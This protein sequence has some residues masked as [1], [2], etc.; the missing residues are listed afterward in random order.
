MS[1]IIPVFTNDQTNEEEVPGSS[2]HIVLNWTRIQSSAVWLWSLGIFCELPWH[3]LLVEQLLLTC[4]LALCQP[5]ARKDMMRQTHYVSDWGSG[6]GRVRTAVC[7]ITHHTAVSAFRGEIPWKSV[8][9]KT[10]L[11]LSKW[12]VLFF[13]WRTVTNRDPSLF[14]LW[15]SSESNLLPFSRASTYSSYS[16]FRIFLFLFPLDSRSL[17]NLFYTTKQCIYTSTMPF[18]N[19]TRMHV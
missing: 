1:I 3:F 2:S 10:M 18:W 4:S 11:L 13:F 17:D 12:F 19:K 5:P 9:D 15:R 7:H 16:E 8:F 6:R 14:W